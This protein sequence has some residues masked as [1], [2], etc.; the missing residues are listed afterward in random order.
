MVNLTTSLEF[1]ESWNLSAYNDQSTW[2][3]NQ[4]EY[5]IVLISNLDSWRRHN[6]IYYNCLVTNTICP[7]KVKTINSIENGI[8]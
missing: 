2:N 5:F 1:N 6:V 8:D 7:K 4:D 3:E